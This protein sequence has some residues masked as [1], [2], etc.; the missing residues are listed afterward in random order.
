[1]IILIV[2]YLIFIDNLYIFC[3]EICPNIVNPVVRVNTKRCSIKLFSSND[4]YDDLGVKAL[5][6]DNF[7]PERDE[8]IIR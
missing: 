5:T 1:M 3:R 7:E 6:E 2:T 4:D 8:T